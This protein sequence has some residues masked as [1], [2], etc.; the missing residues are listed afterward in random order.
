MTTHLIVI[1]RSYE[2]NY[3]G[4]YDV[5]ARSYQPNYNGNLMSS[6]DLIGQ[7]IMVI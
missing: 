5:I 3:Y 6:P 7:I 2:P 4:I 1:A